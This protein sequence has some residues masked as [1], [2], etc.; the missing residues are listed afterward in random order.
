MQNILQKL[1]FIIFSVFVFVA[2]NTKAADISAI[3]FNGW[4]LGKVI[5]DG[6]VINYNNELIGNIT[7]DG[8]VIDDKNTLIGGITPQGVAI[9][10]NNKI[11]GKVNNDGSV[12]SNND[13][14]IGKVLPTGLVVDDNYSILGAV[15]S[16]GLVYD[17]NGKIIG[18]ISGDG[19]FYN[20]S[21]EKTGYV[22]ANGDVYTTNTEG[23][24][25]LS[26][27][28]ISS[29][30]IVSPNGKF[31]GSISPD[32]KVID[33][34]KRIIGNIH[35][36][37]FAYDSNNIAIGH[38][39][40]GGFAFDFSGQYIGV[41]SYNGEV[42]NNGKTIAYAVQKNRIINKDNVQIGFSVSSSAT[43][44]TLR[45]K[46]LGR[47]GIN[48]QIF[49]GR[50]II[51]K[52]GASGNVID[53]KGNVIGAINE[54]GPI[55]DYLG[56]NNAI[57]TINGRV[58]SLDGIDLGYVVK[59][60]AYDNN[61]KEIGKILHANL[62]YN[63]NNEFLGISGI[64]SSLKY[65]GEEYTTTPYG[66]VFDKRG[67]LVGS[68]FSY[69]NIYSNNGDILTHTALNGKV[70]DASLSDVAKV[71]STGVFFDRNDK[72][73]GRT[74]NVKYATDFDGKNIGYINTENL[75]INS[76]NSIYGKIL[77][78]NNVINYSSNEYIGK[79]NNDSISIGINGD[80]LGIAQ[81]DGVVNNNGENIGKVSSD[82]SIIDNTGALY[83]KTISY[84]AIVSPEC[85]FLG[86]VSDNGNIRTFNNA[87]V[88]M[89]LANNQVVN[90]TENVIGYAIKPSI[91]V[92]NDGEVLGVQNNI[93]RVLNYDNESL[94]CQDIYG[95]IR[96]SQNEVIGISV[97]NSPVMDFN[98]KII[99]ETNYLGEILNNENA[100]IGYM[101]LY[102]SALGQDGGELGVLFQYS[103]AFNDDNIYVG[104]INKHGEVTADNNVVV[105]KVDYTGR[106]I[107]NEGGYGYSLNDLYV[108]DNDGKAIGYISKNGRV[109]S[110]MGE[111]IGSI[112]GGFVL[113]KKQNLIARGL[114]D[115]NIRD[116]NKDIIGFL[117]F[118][119]T[120]VD[121][122][123]VIIGN[124]DK[125]GS[126]KN[127]DG[128]VIARAND[129]QYYKQEVEEPEEN[130]D[131]AD[132][133]TVESEDISIENEDDAEEQ[134]PNSNIENDEENIDMFDDENK[135]KSPSKE[136]R[137]DNKKTIFNQEVE[138]TR[139]NHQIVGIVTTPDGN[140]IGEAYSNNKVIN[141]D[142]EIVGTVDTN[143]NV[144][145]EN[146]NIIGIKKERKMDKDLPI[147]K[148]VYNQIVSGV[149]IS[150]YDSSINCGPGGCVGPGGRYNPK[151]AEIIRQ[152]QDT[153][154]KSLSGKKIG[155]TFDYS[156][157]TGW[158]DKWGFSNSVVSTLRVDMSNMITGDKPIPAVLARSLISLGGAPITAIVE[159][160]IYADA[161]R[162]V[163]IPAGSRI[164]GGLTSGEDIEG[165]SRFN[166]ESGGVKL[167][168]SWERIIR[169][170]GIAFALNSDERQTADAQGRGGGILGYVDEQLIK[171][172]TMPLVSTVAA[173]AVAYMMAADEDATGQVETSKQQAASDARQE[174]LSKMDEIIEEIMEK[175]Q[176]IQPVTY[177]PAGTRLIIYPLQDLWLRTTKDIEQGVE[178]TIGDVQE[179]I[180][181]DDNATQQEKNNVQGGQQN[182]GNTQPLI[183]DNA[184]QNQN[185]NQNPGGS[186]NVGS[187]P[188]PSA[189]GTIG[190]YPDSGDSDE[191]DDADIELF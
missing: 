151:R 160:N 59:D 94:G 3:D 105:G 83:G 165:A 79:A 110:I 171:K 91:V 131:E 190:E 36:N 132:D 65:D 50:D 10:Y 102:G 136:I 191:Y 95:K 172:Y 138:D 32:G 93:G 38:V 66:Y 184:N 117:N 19:Y 161:G 109:Y 113:D 98:N 175:K 80:Y 24:N 145:D 4:V 130:I 87:Y 35:A 150:P 89:L 82:G 49:Q 45:G 189:D 52:I 114:R 180:L 139:M 37:G 16:P 147:N 1:K 18:R 68:N 70:E 57:A 85:E 86:I 8:F 133:K 26:G 153:R 81:I 11:L 43:A 75:V 112:H 72:I 107:L 30:I 167:E 106:V 122:S 125:D 126:I 155:S 9:S 134:S 48:G 156:S 56:R 33:I 101:S 176:E 152:L 111:L 124:L 163:I 63:N 123:N 174:F 99:G 46:Y 7:A 129:L 2:T 67:N 23:N 88:G 28:L 97:I 22:T 41:I 187:L 21:G 77:P 164:I 162:N 183:N 25:K 69:S 128:D 14:I 170:D 169:P 121:N 179:D 127:D 159:R 120:V 31:L 6:S 104:R 177:V 135:E 149:T 108:Y 137:E 74:I 34:R 96:N 118:D 55:F 27:R 148:D 60:T 181:I 154:R 173:S 17:D 141:E 90:E 115:Y 92:G 62:N 100:N 157:Y 53:E 64:N 188:P 168:I 42:I 54:V 20:L 12:T 76:D 84:S 15:I 146:G 71:S 185:P 47:I 116:D 44:N 58:I 119:G 40:N 103:V 143:G 186:G 73:L 5:P 158:Q 13:D 61:G 166:G 51:G 140:Y 142:G 78:N 178:S 144:I 182:Q 39:V 29:K